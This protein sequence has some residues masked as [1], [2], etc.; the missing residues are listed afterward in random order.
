M[1]AG[2]V[3]DIRAEESIVTQVIQD[4]RVE[5]A[6]RNW[7]PRFTVQGVDPNDFE[8]T[9]ARISTWDEWCREWS[10][11]AALHEVLAEEREAAGHTISAGEAYISAALTTVL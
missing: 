4:E 3:A 5:Y 6:I 10:A 9:V 11:T 8:R 1:Q 2:Q 7:A